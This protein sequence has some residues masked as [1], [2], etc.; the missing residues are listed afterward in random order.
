MTNGNK[1]KLLKNDFNQMT[2]SD[3]I[4]IWG[5]M[6]AMAFAVFLLIVGIVMLVIGY[7]NKNNNIYIGWSVLAYMVMHLI[8]LVNLKGY[9]KFWGG[10]AFFHHLLSTIAN[11][12]HSIMI[13]FDFVNQMQG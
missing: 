10:I 9:R 3:L 4:Q 12:L 11:F 2:R 7:K 8:M 1:S 13:I 6:E 5:S